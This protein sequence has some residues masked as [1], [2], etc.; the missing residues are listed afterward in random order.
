VIDAAD[1]GAVTTPLVPKLLVEYGVFGGA[2][3]V[4]FLVALF[5]GGV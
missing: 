4:L 3:F 5:S 1:Q 2:V